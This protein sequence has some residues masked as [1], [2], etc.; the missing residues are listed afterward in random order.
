MGFCIVGKIASVETIA[1]GSG[2]RDLALLRQRYGVGY[3]RKKK[4]IAILR[5]PD[6]T[7][8]RAEIHWYEAHGIGK[9]TLKIKGWL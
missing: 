6:G 4:G 8:A 9:A 5:L 3:W 7:T 2:I 1:E